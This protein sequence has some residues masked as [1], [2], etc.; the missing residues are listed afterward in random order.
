MKAVVIEQ[1]GAPFILP[2][3]AVPSPAPG[4]ILIKVLG[5]GVCLFRLLRP[6]RWIWHLPR[7]P[8]HEVIGSW[9]LGGK[10]GG[11]WHCGYDGT[12]AGCQGVNG[13]TRDGGRVFAFCHAE[14]CV[15]RCEAVIRIPED[16][17]LVAYAPLMAV[18]PRATIGEYATCRHSCFPT[19]VSYSRDWRPG[20]SEHSVAP[21]TSDSKRGFAMQLGATNYVD[22]SKR[23]AANELQD[24]GGASLIVVTAPNAYI[25]SGLVGALGRLGKL[26]ILARNSALSW[27]FLSRGLKL[28]IGGSVHV[29]PAG[30]ALD[31]EEAI[32]FAKRQGVKCMEEKFLLEMVEKAIK[33]LTS[34]AVRFR[35]VPVIE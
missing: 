19:I 3:I 28:E 23:D 30:H 31:S 5:C 25:I 35:S 26:L 7:I 4:E 13:V 24:M 29:W 11:G 2:T 14:D 12:C 6:A 18:G 21:S 1:P 15:L 16:A 22:T 8:E 34:N 32:D 10:V 27:S 33:A 9:S 20:S 17:D